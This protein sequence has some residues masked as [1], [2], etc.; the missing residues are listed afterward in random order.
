MKTPTGKRII[1]TAERIMAIALMK[2]NATLDDP[3]EDYAE[4]RFLVADEFYEGTTEIDWDSQETITSAQGGRIFIDEDQNYWTEEALRA[5]TPPDPAFTTIIITSREST[6]VRVTAAD[7]DD[8][9]IGLARDMPFVKFDVE[10][11]DYMIVN[12]GVP[13]V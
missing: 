3:I 1:A 10:G 13:N 6:L 11:S 12:R 4:R 8:E 5:G 9:A 7:N 2:E